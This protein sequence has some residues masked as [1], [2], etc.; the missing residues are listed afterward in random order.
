M[1]RLLRHNLRPTRLSGSLDV[2]LALEPLPLG[3][4]RQG[5]GSQWLAE[6]PAWY[7]RSGSDEGEVPRRR[8]PECPA[9]ATDADLA[10]ASGTRDR[11]EPDDLGDGGREGGDS[12]AYA[13]VRE[14]RPSGSLRYRECCST[15]ATTSGWA[16]WTSR[17]RMP[18][19]KAAASPMTSHE[20]ESGPQQPRVAGVGEGV[21]EWLGA[22]G[23]ERRDLT[24]DPVLHGTVNCVLGRS[25]TP[26]SSASQITTAT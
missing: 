20:T 7:G 17:A 26:C 4:W 21:G 14:S 3:R 9:Q 10:Q 1:P 24:D 5:V 8:G 23:E 19:T 25:V 22:M 12:G 16:A 6:P 13:D 15:P 11:R 2:G 18:P